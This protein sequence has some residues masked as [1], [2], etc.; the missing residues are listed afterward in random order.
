MP[1]PHAPP[2]LTAAMVRGNR[3][4]SSEI[5]LAGLSGTNRETVFTLSP[6][7]S[8]TPPRQE[9]ILSTEG[10]RGFDMPI[11]GVPT[12]HPL[13]VAR[14]HDHRSLYQ[15]RALGDRREGGESEKGLG[16]G[17]SDTNFQV[18]ESVEEGNVIGHDDGILSNHLR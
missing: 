8:D 3:R 14:S 16:G 13:L 7:N 11:S 5:E 17:G 1:T 18:G 10:E 12:P 2:I 4:T 15:V 6:T 9:P